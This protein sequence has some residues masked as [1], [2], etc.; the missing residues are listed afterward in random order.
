MCAGPE[1]PATARFSWRLSGEP[2]GYARASPARR[3]PD[4]VEELYM[5]LVD[6]KRTKGGSVMRGLGAA[7]L[8]MLPVMV[9]GAPSRPP[10]NKGDVS[11][12]MG[13]P[14]LVLLKTIPGLALFYGGMVRGKNVLSQLML[15]LIIF[16]S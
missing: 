8:L 5:Q 12:L 9:F 1:R 11:W 14:V 13:A 16:C 4:V 10:P 3:Q 15:V 6:K 2:C 7:L